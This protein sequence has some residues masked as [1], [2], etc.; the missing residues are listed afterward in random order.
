MNVN[1]GKR[2]NKVGKE[3]E[4]EQRRNLERENSITVT[5]RC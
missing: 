4:T 1:Q 3:R 5:G 2:V